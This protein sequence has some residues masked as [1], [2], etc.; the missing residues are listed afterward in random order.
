ML[1]HSFSRSFSHSFMH[2]FRCIWHL[3]FPVHTQLLTYWL[4]AINM[5]DTVAVAVAVVARQRQTAGLNCIVLMSL[6]LNR[7]LCFPLLRWTQ[8][9]YAFIR[10]HRKSVEWHSSFDH[11]F[12]QKCWFLFR[13]VV[14]GCC[15]IALCPF[16][17][18]GLLLLLLPPPHFRS[19]FVQIIFRLVLLIM[20]ATHVNMCVLYTLDSR[21]FLLSIARSL[22]LCF[23]IAHGNLRDAKIKL[24]L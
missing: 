19:F 21:K 2:S 6:C 9:Q 11:Q 14:A 16:P 3:S 8:S 23:P 15:V 12:S 18:F 17:A 13:C 1:F 24:I 5:R 7:C 4:G 22:T 10:S 20:L